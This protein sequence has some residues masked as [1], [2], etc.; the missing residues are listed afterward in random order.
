M[1]TDRPPLTAERIEA[2]YR[3]EG[4][5]AF[6]TLVRLLADFDRAEEAL[7]DAVHTALERWPAAARQRRGF[8]AHADDGH[9]GRQCASQFHVHQQ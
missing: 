1:A 4:R 6:A 5:R 9:R 3:D 8:A 2:I 7:Y